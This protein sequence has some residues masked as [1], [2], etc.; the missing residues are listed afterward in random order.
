MPALFVHIVLAELTTRFSHRTIFYR[1]RK[2]L[3]NGVKCHLELT[4]ARLDLLIKAS[5]YVKNLSNIDFVYAD[6]YCRLKIQFSIKNVSI[7]D[8][9]NDLISKTE[10]FPNEI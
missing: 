2:E 8:S 7:F 5:K 6:I 10:G 9:M 1:K 4:K 3:K